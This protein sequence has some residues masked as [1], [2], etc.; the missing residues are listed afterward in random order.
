MMVAA[1]IVQQLA[2]DHVPAG[3]VENL[4]FDQP[5]QTS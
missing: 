5:M 2:A 3:A 4:L 1:M